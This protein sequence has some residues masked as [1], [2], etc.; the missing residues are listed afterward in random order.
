[1]N[2]LIEEALKPV[3]LQYERKGCFSNDSANLNYYA[4]HFMLFLLFQKLIFVA[5]FVGD[6]IG[7][8]KDA[9]SEAEDRFPK[10]F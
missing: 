4:G 3:F 6:I 7:F 10:T 9:I 8:F 5:Y 2:N 1:M